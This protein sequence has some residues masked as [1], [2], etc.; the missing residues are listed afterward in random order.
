MLE[1]MKPKSAMQRCR[2]DVVGKEFTGKDLELYW[3]YID[4]RSFPAEQLSDQLR[5]RTNIV[6]G[7]SS[8]RKH[9]NG[10]CW[11]AKLS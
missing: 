5:M 7:A 9:R 10:A 8:I 4:D 6:M 3:Q 2:V 1:G 11:C